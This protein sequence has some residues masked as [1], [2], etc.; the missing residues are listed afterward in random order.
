MIYLDTA[1]I[2]RLYCEDPGWDAVRSLAAE[3]QVACSTLGYA[4]TLAAFHRKLREGV[5][6]PSE[7]QLTFEQFVLDCR[8]GAYRWLPLSDAVNARVEAGFAALPRAIWLRASD[9]L[10][11]ASA[12][13]NNFSVIYSNDQR[14]LTAASHFGLR[15][16]DVIA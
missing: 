11:L 15:G 6:A 5:F 8:E 16:I 2:V 3:A 14:L 1:Y 10:H 4:E 9:G 7:Y 13:E 12:A